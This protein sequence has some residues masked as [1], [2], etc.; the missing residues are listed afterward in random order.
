MK[1]QDHLNFSKE[2]KQN[3]I[4]VIELLLEIRANLRKYAP[5]FKIPIKQSK[6]ILEN[7]ENVANLLIP[8]LQ[9]LG[10]IEA[11]NPIEIKKISKKFKLMEIGIS[12]KFKED[13]FISDLYNLYNLLQNKIILV[14]SNSEKKKLKKIGISLENI[15]V[16]GGPIDIKDYEKIGKKLPQN[17]L[18]ILN[19]KINALKQDLRN[20]VKNNNDIVFVYSLEDITDNI[21]R[22]KIEFLEKEIGGKIK[23]I[24]INSWKNL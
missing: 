11:K 21:N 23:I 10:I 22:T 4:S 1:N 8:I 18:N 16:I 12:S 9:K 20:L 13:L 24:K 19:K 6:D 5:I 2:D 3:I 7:F 17:A 15:K 14:S